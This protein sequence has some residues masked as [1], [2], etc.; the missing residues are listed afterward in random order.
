MS[1]HVFPDPTLAP[2]PPAGPF[3]AAAAG[4]AGDTSPY[5]AV[6]ELT[7][8]PVSAG[9]PSFFVR[10]AM[11]GAA[12]VGPGVFLRVTNT[13]TATFGEGEITAA[14]NGGNPAQIGDGANFGV[15]N[16]VYTGPD[17]DNVARVDVFIFLTGLTFEIRVRNHDAAPRQ[18]TWV[19]ATTEAESRQGWIDVIPVP[20]PMGETTDVNAL[21]NQ[22][23]APLVLV[24]VANRGT[25]PLAITDAAGT[26]LTGNFTLSAVS[27]PIAPNTAANQT[28]TYNPPAAIGTNNIAYLLNSD[29]PAASVGGH[30]RLISLSATTRQLEVMLALDGSGSMAYMPNGSGTVPD[31]AL[32]RWGRLKS[33]VEQFLDVLGHLSAGQGRFGVAVF[34]NLNLPGCPTPSPTAG[35]LFAA[36]NVT[37]AN[38]ATAITAL[39]TRTPVQACAATPI[40]SGI[41]H[42]MGANAGTFGYFQGSANAVN[43]NRRYMVLMSDGKHNSG[44]PNPPDFYGAGGQSFLGKK[45]KAITVAYGETTG[46]PFEVDHTL[47]AAISAASTT[48]P[49]EAGALTLDAGADDEGLGLKAAFKNIL[50]TGLTLAPTLDPGGVLTSANSEVRPTATI[51]PYDTRAVF[52]LNW[53]Q[54][55]P[56]RL[57]FTLITPLCEVITPEVARDHPHIQYANRA[58][59][60]VYTFDNEYLRNADDPANPRYGVWTLII[61]GNFDVIGGA[62]AIQREPYSYDVLTDS[63]LKLFAAAERA[64][65]FAG[66]AIKLSAM[67]SLDLQGIRGASV[68]MELKAPGQSAHNFIALNPVSREEFARATKLA[69]PVDSNAIGIKALA[70][71][72]KKL[73]FDPAYRKIVLNATDPNNDGIYEATFG[74]N[75][76]PGTYEFTVKAVGETADGI[77]FRREKH[78]TV[79]VGVRPHPDFTIFDVRYRALEG[80]ELFAADVRVIPRD[81]FG[82]VVLVDPA[83]ED[84][85][86]ITAQGG[87]LTGRLVGNL[88]GSYSQTVQFRRG[89][90]P[91]VGLVVGSEPVVKP[92]PLAPV[93]EL[94]FVDQVIAFEPGG[95]AEPGANQHTDPRAALGDVTGRKDDF[96]ALGAQGTLTVGIEGKVI[97]AQGGENADDITVFVGPGSLRSYRVDVLTG[98]FGDKWVTLGTSR[99]VT[100]SFSLAAKKVR[101]ARA[102]RIADISGKTRED[103][104]SVS[105]APAARV[106]SLGVR[107]TGPALQE[108]GQLEDCLDAIRRLICDVVQPKSG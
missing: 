12:G 85:V 73:T 80:R 47:L 48:V 67:P 3:A 97:L 2:L 106:S 64:T 76:A 33:A 74:G 31:P 7:G 103:D 21:T 55:N 57:N 41:A 104:M 14:N 62:S 105:H 84:T 99:G 108:G 101:S 16:A 79:I 25:G 56:H 86:R 8:L 68:T 70:L 9:T 83:L 58:T 46:T 13:N 38:I 59:Y 94:T 63:R 19:A 10:V 82:N 4:A 18:L 89:V 20:L 26:N 77:A 24:S 87:E 23:P 39:G 72:L 15:V 75:T 102:V 98:T 11:Q 65:Y 40:G 6:A 93:G 78:V 1:F 32:T 54:P 30:N 90:T 92:A 44:P 60:A 61:S 50:V 35:D 91:R 96:V 34:P 36:N 45:V 81:R 29:D 5:Q 22:S 28:V 52:S 100:Q 88:D 66:D 43:L 71:G 69:D 27:T 51:T 17:A 42:V 49:G 107:R 53:S 95:E 37:A